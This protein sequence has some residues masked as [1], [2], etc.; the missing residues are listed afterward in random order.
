VLC[1]ADWVGGV[2]GS[3]H[4][5]SP[6]AV[7]R[8]V[9]SGVLRCCGACRVVASA[10]G[11]LARSVAFGA[12]RSPCGVVTVVLVGSD[13]SGVAGA[14]PHGGVGRVGWC[15]G[16]AG[17]RRLGLASSAALR[18]FGTFGTRRPPCRAAPVAVGGPAWSVAFGA[19]R[20]PCRRVAARLAR[21]TVFG[22]L[23]RGSV[24]LCRADWVGGVTG[25]RHAW[26]PGAV[27]CSVGSGAL[28]CCGACGTLR[29]PCRVVAGAVG[30]P[31]R[32]G[33]FG[34]PRSPCRGVRGHWRERWDW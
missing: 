14:L 34:A 8:S 33:A 27:G 10:V 28:R 9:G 20:S 11:G 23:P 29:P 30:G 3:R 25:S 17:T 2:T 32:P 15:V 21:F 7:G 1:R 31:V 5:W 19:S 24:V 18:C 6:G 22:T 12:W 26:S 13:R 4:A 16:V